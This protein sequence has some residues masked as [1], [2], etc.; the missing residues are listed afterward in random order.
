MALIYNKSWQ[1]SLDYVFFC[2]PPVSQGVANQIEDSTLG[3][4]LHIKKYLLIKENGAFKY[5]AFDTL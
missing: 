2:F 4:I 5:D 3:R 1:T